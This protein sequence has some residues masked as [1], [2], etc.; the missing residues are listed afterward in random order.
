[1]VLAVAH[2]PDPWASPLPISL[3]PSPILA[4]RS[5]LHVTSRSRPTSPLPSPLTDFLLLFWR[6]TRTFIG[7][8]PTE[9]FCS[10]LL[11]HVCVLSHQGTVLLL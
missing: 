1:M 5:D 8:S 10:L 11:F 7:A 9:L 3:L 4:R 6:D 2:P